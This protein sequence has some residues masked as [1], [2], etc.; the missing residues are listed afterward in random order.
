VTRRSP[1]HQPIAGTVAS[2]GISAGE[3][4][5]A[6]S[7]TNTITVINTG[8][9]QTTSSLTSTQVSPVSVG[10]LVAIYRKSGVHSQA[11]LL[12]ALLRASGTTIRSREP[13][14]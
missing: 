1:T 10:H 7:T 6:G 5:S 9:Y 3:S 8:G 2:V 12:A 13:N 4:V 11:E 14:N